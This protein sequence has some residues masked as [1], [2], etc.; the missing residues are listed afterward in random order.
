MEVC[1]CGSVD[2]DQKYRLGY[3]WVD[4]CQDCGRFE[5][6]KSA[7]PER[8]VLEVDQW[9]STGD[10]TEHTWAELKAQGIDAIAGGDSEAARVIFGGHFM[11]RTVRED[12]RPSLG[13]VWFIE[14]AD[15]RP[16]LWKMNLDSSD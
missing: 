8:E 11:F 16:D 12:E 9:T 6:V 7:M 1:T 14:G 4:E 13:E 2:I 15:G 10:M 3:G 5:L